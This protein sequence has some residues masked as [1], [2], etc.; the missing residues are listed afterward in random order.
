MPLERLKAILS[1][2]GADPKVHTDQAMRALV[3][4]A[5]KMATMLKG[6]E[7]R[8]AGLVASAQKL[9]HYEIAAY[10]TAA[11]LA[12][13][14]NLRPEQRVLHRSLDEERHAD[15]LLTTL[16]KGGVNEAAVAPD[17]PPRRDLTCWRSGAR[18]TPGIAA[19]SSASRR[20]SRLCIPR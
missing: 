9:A 14:L 3:A 20:S 10:G 16:A 18:R 15:L 11:A 7:L 17:V 19:P 13:Q 2:H 4:E 8:D 5:D 12:G 1:K 6:D